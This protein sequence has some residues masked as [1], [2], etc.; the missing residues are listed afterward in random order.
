VTDEKKILLFSLF[1]TF[2]GKK[3]VLSKISFGVKLI[4]PYFISGKDSM[5]RRFSR[6]R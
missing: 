5:W 3:H 2:I 4:N 1:M 6:W